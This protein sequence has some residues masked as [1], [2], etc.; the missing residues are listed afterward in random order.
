MTTDPPTTTRTASS[1]ETLAQCV[2]QVG[3]AWAAE[4]ETAARAE[5]RMLS[6]EAGLLA[7]MEPLPIGATESRR[8]RA[9]PR[10]KTPG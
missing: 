2:R 3:R 1:L 8:Q 9:E 5:L 7:A 4:D 10:V 6:A